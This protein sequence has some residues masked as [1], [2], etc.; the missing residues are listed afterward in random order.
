M[1]VDLARL[2]TPA[3]DLLGRRVC[4][5]TTADVVYWLH[6]WWGG[7]YVAFLHSGQ[8]DHDSLRY[9][10]DKMAHWLPFA[11]RKWIDIRGL[12]NTL[13][14]DDIIICDLCAHRL[15][16]I[17]K[18]SSATLTWLQLMDQPD[19]HTLDGQGNIK[20]VSFALIYIYYKANPH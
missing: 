20:G 6:L 4:S 11:S 13:L 10:C 7:G 2:T 1:C 14:V 3:G 8:W 17:V 19:G 9:S 5:Y 18:L 12:L 15:D 16:M